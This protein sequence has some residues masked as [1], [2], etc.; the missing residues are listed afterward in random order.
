MGVINVTPD[1]FSDGGSLYQQFKP[2]LDLAMARARAMVDEGAAILDVGGESTR[3]G[4]DAV[5]V[6]EE[7]DR[8]LPVVE[9]VSAELDV[10]VSV[11]SST[12]KVMTAAAGLGAG[13]LN[14]VRALAREGALEAAAATKLPVC[15][16]HMQG[17]PGNMQ[18]DPSYNKVVTEVLDY[19][20][21]RVAACEEAGIARH[22]LLIDPGFG[23]G[24]TLEHNLQLLAGLEEFT[25]LGLPVLVGLSRKSMIGKILGRD[26]DERMPASIALALLAAQ[27]GA[28]IIR[29][30]DVAATAD[31]LAMWI[32]IERHR[33]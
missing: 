18:A 4:A 8:V 12:P 23:F 3:P 21:Q 22:R 15:L 7:M 33:E 24:K 28:N 27:R 29:S 32:A 11:D 31:A 9:K 26:V 19:L 13:L 1:S 30:H 20:A 2:N 10:V 14:D 6:Q 25:R 5:S 17:N 16:M